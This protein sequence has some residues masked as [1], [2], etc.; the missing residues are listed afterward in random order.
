MQC[1]HNGMLKWTFARLGGG[2]LA[3]KRSD[4]LVACPSLKCLLAWKHEDQQLKVKVV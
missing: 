4:H 2:N 1:K 3:K